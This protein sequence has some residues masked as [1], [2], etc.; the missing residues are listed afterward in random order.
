V[1]TNIAAT[2]SRIAEALR[3]RLPGHTLPG[4]FCSDAEVFETVREHV[5]HREWVFAGNACELRNPG[6]FLT[7]TVGAYP[8]MVIR[9]DDGEVRALHNVCRH[10][11]SQI[12]DEAGGNSRRRLTCPYHHWSY[13]L[14]GTLAG[15]R[16][17]PDDFDPTDYPLGRA[18]VADVGGLVFVCVAE[19]PPDIESF[20]AM[21]EPYLAPFDLVTAKVAHTSTIVEHGS[22]QL[23]IENNRECYHCQ[24]AHPELCAS[25]P[26][27]PLHSGGGSADDVARQTT[28][29]EQC[30]VLGL[31]SR[32]AAADNWQ[33]RAMRMPLLAGTTSMTLD[34]QPAV[35]RRFPGLPADIDLG[36]VLLYH[37]PSTWN[38]FTADHAVT[39]RA[40]PLTATTTE[41][42]TTWLVPGDAVEGVD[43]DLDRLTE[44]W[45]ATNAQDAALVERA[46]RGIASPAY[47]TGP[48]S[49]EEDGVT[50]FIDWYASTLLARSCEAPA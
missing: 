37:Y 27:G 10:R 49:L 26:A 39:F 12:C 3:S 22:W 24:S 17:M 14:D 1:V 46:Q 44:V 7:L 20:R 34:G 31:A 41:V 35:A 25:F 19:T 4:F 47:R 8:L 40:L 45:L 11:G 13:R 29:V 36:D 30:E 23:V 5:W 38:H 18:H 21:V 6:D 16:A 33:Y 50:Q 9:G 42:R 2:E 43:Y 15:A 28:L 48:Y 32:F